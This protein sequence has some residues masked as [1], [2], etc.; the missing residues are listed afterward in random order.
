MSN[1]FTRMLRA[2][3]KSLAS[4]ASTSNDWFSD[5]V[6]DL[7]KRDPNKVF[8]KFASPQIGGMYLFLYEAK[9]KD[10]LPFYDMYPLAMPVEMYADGFLGINLHYLPPLGR[11]NLLRA[12]VDVNDGNKYTKTKRLTL[13]Y[14]ILKTYSFQLKG[15]E[16]CIKRYLYGHVR[17]SFHQVDMVDWEKAALLQVQRWK[18]NPNRRYAGSPP[19]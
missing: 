10:T 14:D 5:S 17:S 13:S 18:I 2:S 6:E 3:A 11:I 1:A 19:Y 12:L 16:G 9:Y 15:V 4:Q 7:Q 8:Q